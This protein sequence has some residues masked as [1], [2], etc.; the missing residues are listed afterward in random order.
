M[1]TSSAEE[2]RDE[3]DQ[4]RQYLTFVLADEEYAVD[5]LQVQEIKSWTPVTKLPRSPSY[6][7]GVIN[8]RGAIVPVI[9]LRVRFELDSV[10][11]TNKTAVI[12]VHNE[13]TDGTKTVGLVVDQ[14]SEV[15]HFKPEQIQTSAAIGGHIDADYIQ[16][17]AKAD[18]QLVIILKLARIVDYEAAGWV[19]QRT[20]E[21]DE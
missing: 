11:A 3:V 15:Y 13:S 14:V 5:I 1:Q 18:D 6:V 9:D 2:A 21:K 8:L 16:G 17:L 7:L 19:G 4:S 12:I 10:R 20:G